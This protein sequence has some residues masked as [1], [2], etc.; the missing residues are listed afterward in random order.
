MDLLIIDYIAFVWFLVCWIGYTLLADV[1]YKDKSISS[2]T[3]LYRYQWM[4]VLTRRDNRIVDMTVQSILSRSTSFFAS[5]SILIIGGLMALLG[6]IDKVQN[7]TS[8]V[9]FIVSG[10]IAQTE[11]KI[12]CMLLIFIYAFFKFIWSFRLFN[13]CS[14]LMAAVP[15]RDEMSETQSD[16]FA[17]TI[18]GMHILAGKHFNN[19]I[20][21][22]MFALAMLAW[23]INP[24]VFIASSTLIALIIQRREFYSKTYRLLKESLETCKT[25]P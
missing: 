18:S 21:A 13:N 12:F 9:P 20:R 17:K 4:R 10:N 25:V 7:I 5:T 23:F 8:N 6:S 24:Y 19:G 14:I 22:F 2:I 1:I 16:G 3:N 11:F 15:L